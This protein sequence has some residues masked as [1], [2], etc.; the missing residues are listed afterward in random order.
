MTE[1]RAREAFELWFFRDLVDHQ[2]ISL[3][4]L[5][6]GSGYASEATNHGAQ[7][8]CLRAI[9][10]ALAESAKSPSDSVRE[11]LAAQTAV[12]DR[13]CRAIERAENDIGG[14]RVSTVLRELGPANDARA[15]LQSSEADNG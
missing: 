7:R 3:I 5:V 2:R 11:A 4:R 15:A 13:L 10:T 1:Q 8:H 12:V 9:T 14:E 6:L